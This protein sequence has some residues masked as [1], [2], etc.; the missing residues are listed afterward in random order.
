MTIRD[1]IRDFRRVPAREL[2]PHALNWRTHSQAQREALEAVLAEIGYAGA[3]LAREVPGGLELIDGHLRAETTPDQR[4][5]VLVLDVTEDEARQLLAFWDPIAALA[6][7]DEERARQLAEQ[8]QATSPTLQALLDDLRGAPEL[9]TPDAEPS[10]EYEPSYQVVVHCADETEQR[11][12]F[13][14][15]TA[16]GRRCRV[17]TM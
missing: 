6:G 14:Q 15:L 1:R 7:K 11:A 4:V 16:D 10:A 2:R 17:L 9:E 3:L 13:D 5:P 12:L 8:I